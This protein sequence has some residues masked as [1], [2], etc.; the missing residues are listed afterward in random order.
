MATWLSESLFGRFHCRRQSS[1]RF[2]P[3]LPGR[4]IVGICSLLM[5]LSSIGC[6]G[7]KL[8]ETV[9]VTGTVTYKSEPVEGAQV[10][11]NSTDPN[12]KPA[13]GITDAQGKFSVK[14]YVDPATQANGAMPGTYKVTVTKIEESTMSSEE[15]MKAA[16]SGN[17]KAGPKHL[18]P[19][20]YSNLATTDLP[21]EVKK[22]N[23]TPLALE[24]KD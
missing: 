17:K 12:G 18:V 10:V 15:M 5:I 22:G 21:A 16:A 23:T 7:P 1:M 20:K 24:L 13:T 3:I 6:G 9:A 19:E 2:P 4:N 14:T 11:L 8:P